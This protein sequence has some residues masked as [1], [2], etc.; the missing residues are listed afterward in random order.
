MSIDLIRLAA[1]GRAFDATRAWTEEENDAL[2]RLVRE[3]NL[4]R[5]Q[6]ATYVRNGVLTLEAYD[7]AKEIGHEPKNIEEVK[8][9]AVA[10]LQAETAIKLAPKKK[11]KGK[12]K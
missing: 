10:N 4:S 9:D 7:S 12:R 5:E 8:T 6:A 3:R 1:N 2:Y 11:T